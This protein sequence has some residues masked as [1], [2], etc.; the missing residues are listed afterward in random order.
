MAFQ[1]GHK[2][3]GGRKK[4]TPNK[5]HR[6]VY[7]MAEE[8]GVE[9]FKIL[10]DLCLHRDPS[11][12]LNAAKEASKYLYTQKRATELS[13]PGGGPIEAQVESSQLQEILGDLKLL[14]DTKI[15]E[16]KE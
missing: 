8:A 15:H 4:G 7:A 6:D 5:A 10:L 2:K 11:I 14:V 13:G 3:F 1:K 9:P 16:R 12:S